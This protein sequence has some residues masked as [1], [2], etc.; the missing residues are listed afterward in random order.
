MI[1]RTLRLY[2][3]AYSNHPG[4]IW[5][6][7]IVTLINRM[8]TM[9]LPFL[10][11]YLKTVMGFSLQEA[12]I[13]ASAFGFGSLG[14]A[15]L[16]GWLTDRSGPRLVILL[17]LSLGGLCFIGLQLAH[18]FHELFGMIFLAALFGEAYRPAM[19]TAAANFVRKSETG[20][21]MALL[22]MAIN[23]GMA[24]A[25]AIG[26]MVAVYLGYKWLFWIDGSTCIVAAVF[27]YYQSRHWKG[28]ASEKSAA[29]P[30]QVLPP[31][32]NYS[33]LHFLLGTFLICFVFMQWLHTV[34]VFIKSE[35]GFDER[36][37]GIFYA[38]S[39]FIVTVLE[40][41][42]VHSVEQKHKV[43]IAVYI[44]IVLITV[45][46]LNFLLPKALIVCFVAVVIWTMG[47]ILFLPF[48]NS[49]ALNMSPLARRGQYMSGYF[50]TW[51]LANICGP[52]LGFTLIETYGWSF[53]WILLLVMGGGGLFIQ[54]N[55][56]KNSSVLDQ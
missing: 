15:V 43:R 52:L 12:G 3:D 30:D 9:V 29:K 25:P 8:G 39:S 23:I 26:G 11:V 37:I 31:W 13:L 10:A 24:L 51:S 4:E 36:Y 17:S 18:S 7:T 44:G 1:N 19:N 2:R 33:F 47:E 28:L 41:P 22:R 20:R 46:Y 40:M 42:L 35:W 27:F 16:G 32:R 55:L 56:F 6:L 48:N 50:M 53:F 21:T 34:P 38:L 45:S 5:I 54:M 49:M 14:G